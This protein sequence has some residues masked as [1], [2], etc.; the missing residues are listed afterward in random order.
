MT[1]DLGQL[2]DRMKTRRV[3]FLSV[4]GCACI[5]LYMLLD[6]QFQNKYKV[7]AAD[8]KAEEKLSKELYGKLL[9]AELEINRLSSIERIAPLADSLGLS[10]RIPFYKVQRVAVE[11]N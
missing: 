7:L 8:K 11:G 6:I 9:Q 3:I 2:A 4:L 10:L 5:T 1:F